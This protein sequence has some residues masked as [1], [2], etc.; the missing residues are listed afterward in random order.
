MNQF[1]LVS[2]IRSC[3]NAPYIAL[4]GCVS[5]LIKSSNYKYML[6]IYF[7]QIL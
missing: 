2:Y 4:S 6:H 3:T 5:L 7:F 1:I